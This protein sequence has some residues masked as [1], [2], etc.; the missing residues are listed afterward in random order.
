MTDLVL[1]SLQSMPLA[2]GGSFWFPPQA[3]DVAAGHDFTYDLILWLC[4][5]FFVMICGATLYFMV[6]YRK[7]PG[8]KEQITSTH[9]TRL[10]IAWS[11]I[12]LALLMLIFGVSTY[13]YFEMVTP[14]GEELTEI[15]VTAK[16]WNW[17][18]RYEGA[19]LDPGSQYI[20]PE[21]L[22]IKDQPYQLIMTTPDND[23]IHSLFIPA[24]R[25]KQDCV[26][27][28]YN[29]VWFRPT[30]THA[31]AGRPDGFDLFCTEYCG[32]DHSN[33]ITKVF[34]YETEAEWIAAVE[35]KGDIERIEDLVERGRIIYDRECATCHSLD[36]TDLIGPSFLGL[37]G[38]ESQLESGR[39][40]TV[41]EGYVR[42]SVLEPSKEIVAGYPNQMTPFNWG[43]KT[44]AHFDGIYAFLKSLSDE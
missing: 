6:K 40:V 26:P 22:L 7:R 4:I 21:L 5:V 42:E 34:V 35:E 10:E 18:F 20:T 32:K 23:V 30:M 3:S 15:Q 12:P 17:T 14:P 19:P 24:F 31:E 16:Q 36:G 25:V 41:D 43:D 29:K 37:W 44:D 11:V 2:R 9:N 33:M 1:N 38:S 39:S 28:R 27:G 13:W 8:H